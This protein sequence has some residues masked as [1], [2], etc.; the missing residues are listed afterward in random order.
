MSSTLV[1]PLLSARYGF[2][3]WP[4][5]CSADTL[6]PRSTVHSYLHEARE[7]APWQGGALGGCRAHKRVERADDARVRLL[8]RGGNH[9]QVQ[10]AV[11]QMAVAHDVALLDALRREPSSCFLDEGVPA[12][13][14]AAR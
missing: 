4:I 10:I 11:P 6:P 13:P 8:V 5:P 2:F 9:V 1:S 14:G 3:S 12:P 7:R